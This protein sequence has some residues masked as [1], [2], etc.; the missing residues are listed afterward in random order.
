MLHRV[1]VVDDDHDTTDSLAMLLRIWGH[2]VYTAHDGLE[3]LELA[4]T[5]RPEVILL[6]ISLASLDGF[7]VAS[8]IRSKPWGGGMVLIAVTGWTRNESR[9]R[10]FQVGFNYYLIK[11][12][13][14]SELEAIVAKSAFSAN[15]AYLNGR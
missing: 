5:V 15:S 14:L 8:Q 6:D 13:D 11:P 10:A 9:M 12:V 2:N 4:E 7:A 3:C 1:L